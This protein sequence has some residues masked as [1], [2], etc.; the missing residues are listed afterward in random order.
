MTA[1]LIHTGKIWRFSY[2]QDDDQGGSVPSGT[3]LYE[4]VFARMY[5]E[6]PEMALLQQGLETPSL[7]SAIIEPGDILIQNND[8]LEVTAPN[9][10]PYKGLRF[11]IISDPQPSMLDS[12]RYWKVVMR[13]FVIAH[14]NVYQ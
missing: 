1:G 5:S 3:V 12:R 10:S 7:F 9:I 6:K 13:R 2:P 11:V 4:P 14:Q 8:Q